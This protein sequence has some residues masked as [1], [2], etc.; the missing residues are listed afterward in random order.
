MGANPKR[1]SNRQYYSIVGG[2]VVQRQEKHLFDKQNNQLTV[3]RDIV[4]KKTNKVVKKVIELRLES[5]DGLLT[6]AFIKSHD[7]YGDSIELVIMDDGEEMQ[8]SFPFK[9][10][11]AKTFLLRLPN[12]DISE[13]IELRPYN[14]DDKETGKTRAGISIIQKD[15]AKWEKGKVAPYWTKD[16]PGKLPPMEQIQDGSKLVWSSSK[17]DTYLFDVFKRWC[18]QFKINTTEN[19]QPE[20][21][22]DTAA[23]DVNAMMQEASDFATQQENKSTIKEEVEDPNGIADDLPF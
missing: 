9:S 23:E 2:D 14:F 21:D 5:L 11:Y 17:Q 6:D 16:S 7:K 15:V 10:S 18:N 19:S 13:H 22:L 12:I 1:S 4:D 3:E 8:F 20:D